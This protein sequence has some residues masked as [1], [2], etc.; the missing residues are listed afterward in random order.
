[1]LGVRCQAS[2]REK[3]LANTDTE[4][5]EAADLEEM[6]RKAIWP[7]LPIV[8]TGRG[9]RRGCVYPKCTRGQ[10]LQPLQSQSCDLLPWLLVKVYKPH[11]HL[12][13]EVLQDCQVSCL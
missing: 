4:K 8:Q 3:Y 11:H 10:D 1:M 12:L 7:H 9:A 2:H 6:L 5:E 13:Q